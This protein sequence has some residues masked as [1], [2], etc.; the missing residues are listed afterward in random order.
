MGM[1]KYE[2]YPPS[3]LAPIRRYEGE[4]ALHFCNT[5]SMGMAVPMM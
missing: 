1:D 2:G 3:P 4:R 5:L